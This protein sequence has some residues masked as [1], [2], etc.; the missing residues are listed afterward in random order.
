VV[1]TLRDRSG[2]TALPS[3][4]VRCGKRSV[5]WALGDERKKAVD[6]TE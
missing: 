6:G 4:T 3:K 1:G 5:R 2:R